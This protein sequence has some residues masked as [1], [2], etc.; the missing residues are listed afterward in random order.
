MTNETPGGSPSKPSENAAEPVPVSLERGAALIRDLSAKLP[1]SPG[2]Y[3]MLN[4]SAEVLYV[5]KARSLKRRVSSYAQAARLTNR[6]KRMVAETCA[7]EFIHTHTEVEA[8]LLESNMIKKIRPRYNVLL[9]D[10]KSFPSICL[11]RNHDFPQL[12]KHRGQRNIEGDYYG[13]YASG[14]AVNKT[15][16][17][18]QR[19]FQ[20]R[21]CS[22]SYFEQRKR[23]C[24]QYHIKRCSAP[25]VG[26]VTKEQY[27]EQVRQAKD[28][29]VGRTSALQAD[30]ARAMQEHSEAM[31]FEEA[32]KIRD[33][34][35][36]LTALQADQ[37]INLSGI[38]EADVIALARDKGKTCIQVFFFRNGQNMGNHSYFPSH[39]PDDPDDEV[40]AA[41]LMQF[42]DGKPTPAEMIVSHLPAEKD[43]VTEAL[44]TRDEQPRKTTLVLP[45]R[46]DRRQAVDFALSNA[47][48]ALKRYLIQRAG[49]T[50]LMEG[51]AKL[52]DLD[53][54]PQRIEVYDNS[55]I[56]GTG[57]VGAMIVAGPEGFMKNAY[58][59]FNIKTAGAGDDYAMM[60]EVIK[61]RFTR[62]LDESIEGNDRNWPDLVLIDGGQGQLNAVMETLRA[63]EIDSP[64][65]TVVGIAK[66]EDR[67]AG[68]E[69]FFR[70]DRPPFQLPVDDPVLHYL[71]RLRDEAHRFAIGAQRTKRAQQIGANPLDEVSGIGAKRKKALLLHFGSA[72]AVA[73]AGLSDLEKVDGISKAMARLIYGHFHET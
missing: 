36:A 63:L 28:L 22:D 49:D 62:A 3:R 42:Y 64:D 10:D 13:P 26:Y 2:V 67:N 24:L 14:N 61:R 71:Q 11:T 6:L 31:R 54:P 8:L 25:C 46:G 12:R 60:R 48:D 29:L 72:K 32:A 39:G 27:A 44:R 16:I 18:L 55:H 68:R 17:T 59:K 53:T 15:F 20:L 73:Q 9:K 50:A 56:G 34:I 30:L 57:M 21:N 45:Q 7:M 69:R 66:G 4:N 58:R 51:V 70:P 38:D 43:L 37:R 23:P 52:F 65:V 5:G 47:A 33:R 1:D 35:R 40:M 41:F 19:A